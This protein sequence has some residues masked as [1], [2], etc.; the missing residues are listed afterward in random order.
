MVQRL[1]RPIPLKLSCD[2]TDLPQYLKLA[3]LCAE[4]ERTTYFREAL[5]LV[6]GH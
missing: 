3:L 1:L 4:F 2:A 6:F 5:P